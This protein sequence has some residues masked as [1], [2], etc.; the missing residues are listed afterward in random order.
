MARKKLPRKELVKSAGVQARRQ[1]A[2]SFKLSLLRSGKQ[3]LPT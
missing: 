1:Y 3:R 2:I